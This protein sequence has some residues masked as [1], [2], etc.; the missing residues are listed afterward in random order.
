MRELLGMNKHGEGFVKAH[1]SDTVLSFLY[2]LQLR[3]G[4]VA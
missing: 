1:P 4:F 3:L 2:P